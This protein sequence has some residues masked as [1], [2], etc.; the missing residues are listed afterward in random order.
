MQDDP[1]RYWQDLT[2]N[3]RQMSDG[4]LLELGTKPEDL[5]EIARQ[6]LRDEMR[7]RRL[8]EEAPAPA[9]APRRTVQAASI[10]WE[11]PS[12]R[13]AFGPDDREDVVSDEPHEFTWKTP[14]CE[15]GSQH[16]AWQL[17][18]ALRRQGIESWIQALAN[19]DGIDLVTPRVLVA[20]DELDRARII[21]AQ[22]IPPDILEETETEVPEFDAPVCPKCGAYD[23]VLESI[24]PVNAWICEAC[25]AEWSDPEPA[26][27]EDG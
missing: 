25:G 7:R 8:D 16:Q 20:A 9:E 3:Y 6:V 27:A 5:T 23:P 24:D 22:P 11:S 15:C 19:S 1:A 10:H 13:R 14:L 17:A 2:E 12:S 21:A 18:E 4:E 26:D